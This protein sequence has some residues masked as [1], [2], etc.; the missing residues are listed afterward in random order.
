M[1]QAP[2]LFLA[3]FLVLSAPVLVSA[4]PG[5][6]IK[7]G[8]V[9]YF[10]DLSFEKVGLFFAFSPESKAKKFLKYADERAAEIVALALNNETEHIEPTLEKYEGLIDELFS[11]SKNIER[12]PKTEGILTSILEQTLRHQEILSGVSDNVPTTT[13]AIIDH[14][15]QVSS[16]GYDRALEEVVK[17][18]EE[19]E[20]LKQ[21][22]ADI[23]QG[24]VVDQ[25]SEIA[26]LR[27][28]IEKLKRQQQQQKETNIVQRVTESAPPSPALTHTPIPTPTPAAKLTIN[29]V[30]PNQVLSSI[31]NVITI[32]GTGFEKG[33]SVSIGSKDVS[34]LS[35][36]VD[37]NTATARVTG[38]FL[39]GTY[40]ISV[41]NIDGKS[42]TYNNAL[43]IQE[44]P[45]VDTADH[46]SDAEIVTR[47]DKATVLI[48]TTDVSACG[49]GFIFESNGFILTNAHVVEGVQTIIVRL[50]S[51]TKYTGSVVGRN[52][53]V[54]L[55]VIKVIGQ[56]S[57]LSLGN[58][59]S[60]AL[61]LTSDV[62]AFG[63][64]LTFDYALL[65]SNIALSVEEGDIT[66]RRTVDGIEY[67]QTNARIHGGNSGG[68][69]INK[70]GEVV[71]INTWGLVIPGTDIGTGIGFAV[72]SNKAKEVIPNLKAGAQILKPTS[73]SPSPSPTPSSPG[74]VSVSVDSSVAAQNLAVGVA[75]QPLAGIEINVSNE[76]VIVGKIVFDII[77]SGVGTIA[78]ATIVNSNGTPVAGPVDATNGQLIFIDPLS[79]PVGKSNFTL[80]G[81]LTNDFVNND[82][83]RLRTNP[84]TDWTSVEGASTGDSLVPGPSGDITLQQMTAK[85]AEAIL[86]VSNSV[87]SRILASGEQGVTFT[88]Y[89]LDSKNSGEDVRIASLPLAYKASEGAAANLADCRMWDGSTAIS[90][91]VNPSASDNSIPFT[92]SESL[93]VPKGTSKTLALKCNTVS[94]TTGKYNWGYDIS[95][96]PSGSGV[97]SGQHVAIKEPPSSVIGPA[98]TV[99]KSFPTIE[100]LAV[101]TN[102]LSNGNK[103]LV[104]WRVNAAP[105]GD[106]RI[107]KFTLKIAT[108]TAKVADI[109]IYCYSNSSFSSVCT[110]LQTD[111]TFLTSNAEPGIDGQVE[112]TPEDASGTATTVQIPAGSNRYFEVR[113]MVSGSA[114]GASVSTQLE[115]DAACLQISGLLGTVLEVENY[116]HNDFIWSPGNASLSDSQ[117]TN[118]CGIQG[119]PSTNLLAETLSQ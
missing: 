18:R 59:N 31:A 65:G 85:M 4:G 39:E 91:V 93:I 9:F 21:E 94:G 111:G 37:S 51:G 24:G 72:P 28:E 114:S 83:I 50:G 16:Q 118:G 54:D 8:S 77:V 52:E 81:R 13:K 33:M 101:P 110:G 43:K 2:I 104:R 7:P 115:G 17:L 61:P 5:A 60:S 96:S 82:T 71:G 30:S 116:T 100:R 20:A 48:C 19:I 15:I 14:A 66:A 69:L 108:T 106:I 109:D 23:Q 73:P 103:I 119:L 11:E 87:S 49:S 58:S 78:N 67:L 76:S 1:K 107:S 56:F 25:S 55:A 112:I 32:K 36:V 84:S 29:E 95:S 90:N 88:N 34:D 27:K 45:D 26:E 74:T 62:I 70:R 57:K 10:L 35:V 47:A 3:I 105:Q 92:F 22:I 44:P 12:G 80:R 53:I 102:T 89:V 46:L 98:V 68:P 86:S 42:F 64:P 38:D 75:D 117:W 97:T 6:G 41:R 63:Y 99:Y 113:A 79:F 40:D